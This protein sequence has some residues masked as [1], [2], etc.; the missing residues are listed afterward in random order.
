LVAPGT[1][2]AASPN[3]LYFSEH[4]GAT[5]RDITPPGVS[6]Q[7][8]IVDAY[9]T[10]GLHGFVPLISTAE[11]RAPAMQVAM[12]RDGGSSWNAVSVDISHASF[13]PAWPHQP[14]SIAF[15]D[16]AHGWILVD[17][18]SGPLS[19][20]GFLLATADAGEHWTLM[21]QPPI[22]GDIRFGSSTNGILTTSLNPY[23]STSVWYTRDGGQT[24][25]ASVFPLPLGCSRCVVDQIGKADFT[26][27]LNA[28]V[29]VVFKT[30]EKDDSRVIEY[31]TSDGGATW[32][33]R[34]QPS[35]QNR[36]GAAFGFRA[37]NSGELIGISE[38]PKASIDVTIA[39]RKTS[40]A[41][42]KGIA[43]G[44]VAGISVTSDRT[45][46]VLYE[47]VGCRAGHTGACVHPSDQQERVELLNL[48]PSS[49]RAD[50][51][52]PP[53]AVVAGSPIGTNSPAPERSNL[54]SRSEPEAAASGMLSE[55][56]H[57]EV[58]AVGLDT[59]I[60][61]NWYGI[62][63][64]QLY[65]QS[66]TVTQN[67][68]NW[69][70]YYD[71]GVY[72]GGVNRKT[73]T[74]SLSF[75][76][77]ALEQGWGL[78][79]LYVGYQNPCTTLNYYKI[80][81][82]PTP[83]AQGTSDALDAL[84]KA[85]ALELYATVVYIDME[86]L[87]SG[88]TNTS[89]CQTSTLSY[90]EAFIT[91]AQAQ[92]FAVGVYSSGSSFSTSSSGSPAYFLA[93][94]SSYANVVWDATSIGC[95][96]ISNSGNGASGGCSNID[97]FPLAYISSSEWPADGQRMQQFT[98]T[99]T[100]TWPP[101]GTA[102]ATSIQIDEDFNNGLV[103]PPYVARALPAPTLTYPAD[104][105]FIY[106]ADANCCSFQWTEPNANMTGYQLVI[107]E[108][109]SALPTDPESDGCP[110]CTYQ[111]AIDSTEGSTTS[112]VLPPG[113]FDDNTFYYWTVKA[114][115][116]FKY[117]NWSTPLE[118]CA[119][120]GTGTVGPEIKRSSGKAVGTVSFNVKPRSAGALS[121]T[122]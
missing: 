18:S 65:L 99:T 15:A 119:C 94:L 97:L 9:F 83:T 19:R 114:Y 93:T 34:E 3:H 91:T 22:D 27:S 98:G 79:P 45:A 104:T 80:P 120:T 47:M 72:I 86:A 57:P 13:D 70:P 77:S 58:G 87:P 85:E 44:S 52:T 88:V 24:W 31:H 90:L 62:D 48:D 64:L 20:M 56:A 39:G 4:N 11:G 1:G 8:P 71:L 29:P 115:G 5:W 69:S 67:W 17:A 118:F 7:A 43:A 14:M 66:P 76:Q 49:G 108:D 81:T 105:D 61:Q 2:W 113:I 111:T 102:G 68:W 116:M 28:E 37:M 41:L 117:G 112:I 26:A 103:Y 82:S 84:N 42:P 89:S 35:A 16:S 107:D 50:L 63:G 92:G 59:E 32:T 106:L 122:K 74:I 110:T 46:W 6:A 30:P 55:K 40:L 21:P 36:E 109:P 96:T 25:T 73:G 12:T 101:A 53:Q 51:I 95:S 38:A 78:A 23:D 121:D 75:A 60:S 100:N 33:A 10:D 54:E